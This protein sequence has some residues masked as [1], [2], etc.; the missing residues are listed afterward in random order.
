MTAENETTMPAGMIIEIADDSL[1]LVERA[2]KAGIQFHADSVKLCKA[3][4]NTSLAAM[5][6]NITALGA[7][8]NESLPAKNP[9]K[10]D[11]PVVNS[12]AHA[13]TKPPKRLRGRR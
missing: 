5:R 12:N 6:E 11:K 2:L 7:M 1:L 9:R 8:A 4:S 3:L 13:Q 10:D